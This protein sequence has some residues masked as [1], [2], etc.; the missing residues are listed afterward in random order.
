MPLLMLLAACGGGDGDDGAGDAGGTTPAGMSASFSD[1]EAQVAAD[2]ARL[3]LEDF[4]TGWVSQTPDP[5]EADLT[6]LPD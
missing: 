3:N 6:G 2:L 5:T 1:E 4:P